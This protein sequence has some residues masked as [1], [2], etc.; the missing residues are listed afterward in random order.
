MKPVKPVLANNSDLA[1]SLVTNSIFLF[2]N[3]IGGLTIFRNI[4]MEQAVTF[5]IPKFLIQIAP[6]YFGRREKQTYVY[7]YKHKFISREIIW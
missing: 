4:T 7:I 2:F 3:S 1:G 5:K 6:L